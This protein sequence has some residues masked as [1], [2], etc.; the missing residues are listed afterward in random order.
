MNKKALLIKIIFI[1]SA[2]HGF[3]KAK[4]GHGTL[5]RLEPIFCYFPK[6]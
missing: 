2:F 5:V 6:K 1:Y 4:L 3:G